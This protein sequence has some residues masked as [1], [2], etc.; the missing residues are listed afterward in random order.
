MEKLNRGENP[1]RLLRTASGR[2]QNLVKRANR[3]ASNSPGPESL[4]LSG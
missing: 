2:R 3:L 1:E 4:M